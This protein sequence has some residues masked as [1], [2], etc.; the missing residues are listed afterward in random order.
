MLHEHHLIIR[1]GAGLIQFNYGSHLRMAV[2]LTLDKNVFSLPFSRVRGYESRGQV[3]G[4]QIPCNDHNVL[5][6]PSKYGL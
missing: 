2:D 3:K 5:P 4:L 1:I 6:C